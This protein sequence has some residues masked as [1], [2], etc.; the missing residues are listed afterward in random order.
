[1]KRVQLACN[2]CGEPIY[3]NDYCDGH[4]DGCPNY[5]GYVA[6]YACDCDAHYHP[7]C[8]PV[9]NAMEDDAEDAAWRE[10]V[11]NELMNEEAERLGL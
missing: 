11:A 9:C 6:D 10:F 8:C 7:E 5:H 1:V 2:A 4:R 3:E